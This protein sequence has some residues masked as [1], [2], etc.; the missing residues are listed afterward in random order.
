MRPSR[1]AE[2]GFTLIEVVL[3]LAI[4]AVLLGVLFSALRLGHRAEEQGTAHSERSQSVRILADRIAWLLRGAFPFPVRE[5]DILVPFFDGET[6]RVEFVT[7]SVDAYSPGVED[8]AGLKRVTLVVRG[9]AGLVV[10]ERVFFGSEDDGVTEER[11]F[12]LSPAVT[13]IRFEYLDRGEEGDV[14]DWRDE[15]DYKERQTLPAA[16]RVV[17]ELTFDPDGAPYVPPPILTH[18]PT[19]GYKIDQPAQAPASG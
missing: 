3:A 18:I 13:G 11:E 7:T 1:P 4:T 8:R 5:D 17:L 10:A 6:D 9:E 15:W 14:P 12:V 2:G 19:G 16:V